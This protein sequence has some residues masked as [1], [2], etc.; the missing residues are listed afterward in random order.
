MRQK[1]QG[2]TSAAP[3]SQIVQ[4]ARNCG[5]CLGTLDPQIGVEINELL[6]IFAATTR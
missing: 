2:S 6:S 3:S 4:W 5:L 1:Q